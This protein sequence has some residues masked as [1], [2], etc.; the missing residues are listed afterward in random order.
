MNFNDALTYAKNNYLPDELTKELVF[1]LA[2]DPSMDNEGGNSPACIITLTFLPANTR[3]P[4]SKSDCNEAG[5]VVDGYSALLCHYDIPDDGNNG[6]NADDCEDFYANTPDEL[7][8]QLPDFAGSLNYQLYAPT[9]PDLNI[10]LSSLARDLFPDLPND[11]NAGYKNALIANI[12]AYNSGFLPTGITTKDIDAHFQQTPALSLQEGF[13]HVLENFSS[14]ANGANDERMLG[15]VAAPKDSVL[16]VYI[17][18]LAVMPSNY[19]EIGAHTTDKEGN[20][21]HEYQFNLQGGSYGKPATL[22]AYYSANSVQELIELLPAAFKNVKYR[23]YSM[24]NGHRRHNTEEGVRK[25]FPSLL[26]KP[27]IDREADFQEGFAP[28]SEE[29]LLALKMTALEVIRKSNF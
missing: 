2:Y 25:M 14:F 18:S 3:D 10:E 4:Y 17:A 26:G 16:D 8:A 15:V 27:D 7:L 19:R 1:G 13:D 24:P 28:E 29:D 6:N 11:D 22:S 9:D 12:E 21:C 23:V 20:A 5:D